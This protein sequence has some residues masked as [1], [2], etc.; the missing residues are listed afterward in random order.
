MLQIHAFCFNAFQENTYILFNE[1][2][3]AIIVDPGCYL[4]NEQETLAGF[5]AA[6]E[7]TPTLLLNTHC[8]L[9]HVFGNNF[10]S[11]KYGLTALLHE[12]EQVVLDRLPE[13]GAKWGVSTEAYTGPI[14]YI[15]QDQIIALGG[16]QF[17]VLETPGHS[18]GSV[19]FYNE[20]QDFLLGGDLIFMDGV[21]R[22]D[23]PGSNPLDLIHSIRTQII[24]LPDSMTIYSGHG[25][26]TTWGREK[27]HNPYI[28][29]LL[30]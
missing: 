9:D 20:K 12:K 24:P 1:H 22:T 18:P 11:N 14:Q 19:C 2:K 28:K 25:E 26:A 17:K 5:I 3:E 30:R 21:G 29:H 6:H 16:D 4:K 7:L 23:L 27:L 15:Q 8:H 13:A 10:V